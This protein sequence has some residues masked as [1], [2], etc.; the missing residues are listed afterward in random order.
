MH[1]RDTAD[2]GEQGGIADLPG[3]ALV[4]G[5]QD[6][7]AVEADNIGGATDQPDGDG[8]VLREPVFHVFEKQVVGGDRGGQRQ[9]A[10]KIGAELVL[11]MQTGGGA[12]MGD[13]VAVRLQP[14][15]VHAIQRGAGHEADG[16]G[17][18]G[19]HGLYATRV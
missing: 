2:F 4:G 18:F 1:H 13:G 12:E 5:V 10:A 11:V 16:A 3:F 15:D 8:M 6:G 19:G 7:L 17:W 14:G 9:Q